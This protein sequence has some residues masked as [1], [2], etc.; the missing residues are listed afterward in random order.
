M[1]KLAV[2]SLCAR[3]SGWASAEGR[4]AILLRENGVGLF[5][6]FIGLAHFFGCEPGQSFQASCSGVSVRDIT[7]GA[8]G[9]VA[10]VELRNGFSWLSAVFIHVQT[11]A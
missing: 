9:C 8:G 10:C 5:S 2:W 7:G 4:Q 11:L 1:P 6:V 3:E